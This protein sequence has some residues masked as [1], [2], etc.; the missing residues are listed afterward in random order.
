VLRAA[1]ARFVSEGYTGTRMADVAADAGVAV[2]TVYFIFHTKPELL[3]ACFDLAVL[4]A[5]DA[6]SPPRQAWHLAMMAAATADEAV[7]RYVA[8]NTDICE[9]VAVLDD[10]VRATVHEP[11]AVAVHERSERLR[12]RDMEKLVAHLARSFGLRRGLTRAA[13]LDLLLT[14]SGPSVYRQLVV[15]C[16]W[17]RRAYESW[18]RGELRALLSA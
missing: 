10:L 4:G 13:C 6:P 5:P 9:R 11:E 8:G 7:A 1:H 15:D 3:A 16:G 2:Q 14:L 18:L 17:T 12:R